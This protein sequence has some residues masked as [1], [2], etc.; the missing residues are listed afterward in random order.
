M[1]LKQFI[2]EIDLP[3]HIEDTDNPRQ[4]VLLKGEKYVQSYD[5][6]WKIEEDDGNLRITGWL[7]RVYEH[8]KDEY[9]TIRIYS[10]KPSSPYIED[11]LLQEFISPTPRD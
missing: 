7:N 11:D 3:I 6:V 4:L 9:D 1:E 8:K 5:P 10:Y 2:K